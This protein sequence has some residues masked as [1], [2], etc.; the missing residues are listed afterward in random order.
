LKARLAAVEDRVTI[1][2]DELETLVGGLPRSAYD[3]AAF[4]TGA[5]SGWPGFTAVDVVVGEQVTFVRRSGPAAATNVVPVPVPVPVPVAD[6]APGSPD[7]V[8]VG[9]VKSKLPFA[10]PARDLYTSSLF[11]KS[12]AYAEA[13]GAEWYILSAEHGLLAPTT[14]IEP[15]ELRLSRTSGAYRREWG[16]QVVQQ[17]TAERGSL[18]AQRIEIHAGE[19]YAGAIR[20][21]LRSAGALVVEPLNG[22]TMGRRLAWYGPEARTSEPAS[23]GSEALARELADG[24]AAMSPREFVQR[25]PGLMGA[26]GLYSW[27]VDAAGASDL[28]RGLGLEVRPGLIYAGLAGATRVRSGKKS[29]NTLWGRIHGMHLGGRHEFSTFRRSLGS[30]LASARGEREID[31]GALTDW[32]YEHL[33]VVAI[34][35]DDGDVLDGLET[36]VLVALDPPLNLQKMRPSDVRARLSSL[37]RLHGR[38]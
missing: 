19:A 28:T 3:Y 33:R 5:R 38:I 35:V 11:R 1:P 8:L 7:V 17:L 29:T 37:R 2:W 26:P 10:A 18:G 15:Y 22:L 13:T 21:L 24:T 36:G 6:V 31:E 32:M 16:A 25:G 4:W 23:P 34:P 20:S 12:R 14:V 30:I 9:C 27:W